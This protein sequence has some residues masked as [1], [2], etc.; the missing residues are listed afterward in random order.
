MVS[1]LINGRKGEPSLRSS[2]NLAWARGSRSSSTSITSSTFEGEGLVLA[3][4]SGGMTSSSS[5]SSIGFRLA[6]E[7]R[8]LLR[9]LVAALEEP[10]EVELEEMELSNLTKKT[11]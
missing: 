11:K 7:K 3:L 10:V 5:S 2:N 8:S 4:L 6:T 1:L 9:V